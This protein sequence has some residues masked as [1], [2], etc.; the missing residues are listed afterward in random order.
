M[1]RKPRRLRMSRKDGLQL[2]PSRNGRES[3]QAV[4]IMRQRWK[5]QW[6][7]CLRGTTKPRAWQSSGS[8][9]M[10]THT[11]A[12]APLWPKKESWQSQKESM[13][14]A[15]KILPRW[16]LPC[17][18]AWSRRW[19]A[20]AAPS[21]TRVAWTRPKL[22][23]K[24]PWMWISIGARTTRT[25]TRNASPWWHRWQLK[26]TLWKFSKAKLIHGRLRLERTSAQAAGSHGHRIGEEEEENFP[27]PAS[28]IPTAHRWSCRSREQKPRDHKLQHWCGW[29]HEANQKGIAEAQE[30]P[31]RMNVANPGSS[32][33]I[34]GSGLNKALVCA[35]LEQACALQM[36]A[37][38]WKKGAAF[39]ASVSNCFS[40]FL[41][42]FFFGVHVCSHCLLKKTMKL[43][44]WIWLW[45]LFHVGL[46]KA[47][48]GKSSSSKRK[49]EV[50]S[51]K[52]GTLSAWTCMPRMSC[53][54]LWQK[55]T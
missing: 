49:R 31:G 50:L 4:Q 27:G 53:L 20:P 51:Q 47:Q 11:R 3:S 32:C 14:S 30:I 46:Q 39:A 5:P 38:W 18:R 22:K 23:L 19:L 10:S 37:A 8:S 48:A 33:S 7:G 2:K 45:T 15:K 29:F 41:V 55:E 12:K 21:P 17:T 26:S 43:L 6:K 34:Y 9:N 42:M 52:I 25:N 35:T 24:L 1:W 36:A 16:G 44:C 54:Q 28:E 40:W 13:M